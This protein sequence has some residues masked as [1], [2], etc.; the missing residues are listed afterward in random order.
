MGGWGLLAR[1]RWRVR[2]PKS[3]LLDVDT[4]LHE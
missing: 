4:E 1:T 2:M 3:V